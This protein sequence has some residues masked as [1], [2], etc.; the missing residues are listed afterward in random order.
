MPSWLA[1][2]KR[3]RPD[4]FL[5]S[6]GLDGWSLAQDFP[7]T[8]RNREA[9]WEMCHQM[10][11]LVMNAGGKVYFA[12]DATVRPASV[13]QAFG[14]EKLLQF[15]ALRD[16]LDPNGLLATDLYDRALAPAIA[17]AQAADCQAK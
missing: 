10:D 16:E 7:V 9:L 17:L 5:L 11:E 2:L 14:A 13:L 3:H 6:H 15:K 12:K 1:V 4:P 8:P